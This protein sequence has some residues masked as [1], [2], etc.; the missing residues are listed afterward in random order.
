[1]PNNRFTIIFPIIVDAIIQICTHKICANRD[2]IAQYILN[3][4]AKFASK[5]RCI[6]HYGSVCIVCGFDFEKVYGGIG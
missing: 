4:L 6:D 5:K 1:M 3:G 2:N